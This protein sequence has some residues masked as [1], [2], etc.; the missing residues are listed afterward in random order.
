M[1]TTTLYES[2]SHRLNA[3]RQAARDYADT[4]GGTGPDHNLAWHNLCEAAL[5]FAEARKKLLEGMEGDRS[6]F[7]PTDT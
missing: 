2:H 4:D 1:T 6:P 5:D 3:L 7:T